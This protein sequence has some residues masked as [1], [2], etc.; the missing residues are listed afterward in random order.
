MHWDVLHTN[1]QMW[2][3]YIPSPRT[4]A[5]S[6]SRQSKRLAFPGSKKKRHFS[7]LRK[8]AGVSFDEHGSHTEPVKKSHVLHE[9]NG[10][11]TQKRAGVLTVE[12]KE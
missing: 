5:F 4:L 12:K 1:I 11:G 2:V 8:K 7:L 10:F 3:A 9:L 6:V